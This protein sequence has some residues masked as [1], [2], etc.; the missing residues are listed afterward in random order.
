[1]VIPSTPGLPLFLL[2]RFH[3]LSRFSRSHTSSISCSV[4][5]GFS[6]A[7]LAMN[8]SVSSSPRAGASPRS[9]GS[10]A[11]TCW[12]F[13][14]FLFTRYQSYLPLSIV[15][16]FSHR[17]RLR[18]SV[19]PPFGLGVPQWLCGPPDLTPPQVISAGGSDGLGVVSGAGGGHRG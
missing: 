9:F 8:D 19:S 6:V 18:L 7:A 5:A 14:R 2:T 17:F 13:C 4:K 1:M 15:R 3:A 10:K 12:L 11:S 16:A